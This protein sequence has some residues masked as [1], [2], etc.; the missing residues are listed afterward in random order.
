[1]VMKVLISCAALVFL[2]GMYHIVPKRKTHPLF[3][4]VFTYSQPN[5]ALV[6]FMVSGV[7]LVAAYFVS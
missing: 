2:F 4:I 7:L 1:M 6:A 3:D 5:L